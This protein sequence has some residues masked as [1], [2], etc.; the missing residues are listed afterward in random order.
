MVQSVSLW[1]SREREMSMTIL[2]LT[3]LTMRRNVKQRHHSLSLS[4][5]ISWPR[6]MWDLSP[7]TR[8]RTCAP[9]MGST[10]SQPLHCQ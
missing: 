8:D 4:V 5:F 1:P 7:P 9:C 6:G 10:V 2:V 3:L